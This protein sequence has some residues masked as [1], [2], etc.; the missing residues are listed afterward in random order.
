[1]EDPTHNLK[2]AVE[3]IRDVAFNFFKYQDLTKTIIEPYN[4]FLNGPLQEIVMTP[5]LYNGEKLGL[6]EFTNV[7]LVPPYHGEIVPLNIQSKI[8]K[9]RAEKN[10]EL[11]SVFGNKEYNIKNLR[12][13]RDE[14]IKNLQ[15][16]FTDSEEDK[17]VR[18]KVLIERKYLALEATILR[19]AFTNYPKDSWLLPKHCRERKETYYLDIYA[20]ITITEYNKRTLND[21]IQEDE[22]A[23]LLE[24]NVNTAARKRYITQY[25]QLVGAK[26]STY[27]MQKLFSIPLMVGSSW[28]WL[29]LAAPRPEEL[30]SLGECDIAPKGYFIINGTQKVFVTQIKLT[31]NEA[32]CEIEK[33]TGDKSNDKIICRLKC[34]T[35]NRNANNLCLIFGKPANQ[36][37]LKDLTKVLYLTL[38]FMKAEHG[39]QGKRKVKGTKNITFNILWIFRFYVIWHRYETIGQ[40]FES[41]KSKE[42]ALSEFN[43]YMKDVCF[44]NGVEEGSE[45]L[46][47]RIITEMVDTLIHFTSSDEC[48]DDDH[49]FLI[50]LKNEYKLDIAQTEGKMTEDDEVGLILQRF[51]ARM[52]SQFFPQIQCAE[53]KITEA[54]DYW[55]P[56]VKFMALTH[57]MFKYIKCF[58]GA[59]GVDDRDS[60]TTIQLATSG[61]E[62]GILLRKAFSGSDGIRY[63][64]ATELKKGGVTSV[65][66]GV[67]IAIH[68]FQSNAAVYVTNVLKTCFSKG[69]WGLP[70]R[71]GAK[72]T[73]VVQL[74]ET[75]SLM[76][77]LHLLRKSAI[78]M[79]SNS[80]IE[81]PRRV[82]NTTYG[83]IDPTNTPDSDQ[84]G[85]IRSLAMS[86]MISSEN[87]DAYDFV[88]QEIENQVNEG[89]EVYLSYEHEPG[90][91][92]YPLY[93]NNIIA[94]YCDNDFYKKLRKHKIE[95]RLGYHTE[96]Y[97]KREADKWHTLS[98]VHVKT[99]SGRAMRPLIVVKNNELPILEHVIGPKASENRANF[100]YLLAVG[101][102]EFVSVSEFLYSEVAVSVEIFFR[103]R[104]HRR[105]D[106]VELDPMMSMSIEIAT[107]PFFAHN[108][109][110][111]ALY[112]GGMVRQAMSIPMATFAQQQETESKILT[113]PHAPLITTDMAK[114][115][116]AEEQ[117]HGQMVYVAIKSE[118]GT[119]EDPTRWREGFIRNGGLNGMIYQTYEAQLV[120]TVHDEDVDDPALYTNGVINVFNKGDVEIDED[121]DEEIKT[122]RKYSGNRVIVK[123]DDLLVRFKTHHNDET[124][125]QQL[126]VS[127]NRAGFVSHIN[128]FSS[129][130]GSPV[131][132]ITIA[133]PHIP[134]EG[135][136][137]A[138][139]HAQKGVMGEVIKDEDMPTNLETG[140]KPDVIFSP[141]SLPS[142]MT[143]GLPLVMLAGSAFA[144]MDKKRLVKNLI[145]WP[146][147][148]ANVEVNAT[149]DFWIILVE[150]FVHP[151]QSKFHIYSELL[152]EQKKIIEDER[153]ARE[154]NDNEDFE[155]P[156][157]VKNDEQYLISKMGVLALDLVEKQ[158]YK[159][160]YGFLLNIN[161]VERQFITPDDEY[162]STLKTDEKAILFSQLPLELQRSWYEQNE[163][164]VIP[165]YMLFVPRTPN[166]ES[167]TDASPFRQP[168]VEYLMSILESKGYN[169]NGESEFVDKNGLVTKMKIF[170]G[171]LYYMQLAHLTDLKWQ[172]RDQGA[173]S[174]VT[175]GATQGKAQGGA[176]R[177][178]EFSHF[179]M[180]AHR[181][182]AYMTERFMKAADKHTILICK[183][184][185][186][187]GRCH[188]QTVI[189]KVKCE[190]CGSNE[191]PRSVTLPFSGI[192]LLNMIAATGSF[193]SIMTKPDVT[194]EDYDD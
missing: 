20:D 29:S 24:A 90:Q 191:D 140:L 19:K 176:V 99:G 61:V 141:T 4:N 82:H 27:S 85:L 157:G 8:E 132:K 32:R 179:A 154:I 45:T 39:N 15:E 184:P 130:T 35:R 150:G 110:P 139:E 97:L 147:E 73:G 126:K 122:L 183:K 77:Q 125:V 187:G 135:D 155:Y 41:G 138:E 180:Y 186:C 117:P 189:N 108:P 72:R 115:S 74:F 9:L 47:Y 172:I 87:N 164:M 26:S 10:E 59:K 136:K 84:V 134:R 118:P 165:N 71:G 166:D 101:C 160:R 18:Q 75:K 12:S 190:T 33:G 128:F 111:R 67:P 21:E 1:M 5:M 102:V 121:E 53:F 62:M 13:K 64:F 162:I 34:E 76:M 58:V 112:Y 44:Q 48:P 109:N 42:R 194:Q 123:P 40:L 120:K 38:P 23:L 129:N 158:D 149:N 163:N 137:A 16:K 14:E 169:R 7:V 127:G 79:N 50:R 177:L 92:R 43:L 66:N 104:V 65:N 70:Q 153:V 98:E 124:S 57:M 168:K 55:T 188:I 185:G 63:K 56:F 17:F 93:V 142:R 83:I 171:P 161:I 159:R 68:N 145:N 89:I 131:I 143:I 113:Y 152:E 133:T 167:I 170:S 192:R 3:A 22:E 116:R 94:G 80:S 25:G 81:I 175:K 86:V 178:G 51:K 49:E 6:V 36:N 146:R 95:G 2:D 144:S 148:Q 181:V 30:S 60:F 106:Y 119:D 193:V 37:A 96:V 46:Y 11:K 156:E 78:P 114:I 174:A 173:M 107:Q 100:A 88:M 103:D 69:E 151:G 31:V 52:D 105:F 91:I 28:C 54:N 182:D